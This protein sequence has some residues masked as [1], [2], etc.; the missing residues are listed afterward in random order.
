MAG[1][2]SPHLVPQW[3]RTVPQSRTVHDP[4]K[5]KQ[6]LRPAVVGRAAGGE[7]HTRRAA[8][9]RLGRPTDPAHSGGDDGPSGA[10]TLPLTSPLV[11][12][13]HH[14]VNISPMSYSAPKI[15]Y[16]KSTLA[17][18]SRWDYNPPPF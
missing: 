8:E 9:E 13:L 12:S 16:R 15:D 11:T 1:A 7:Q 6:R 14:H 17:R 5:H 3:H 10:A 4:C 18:G 2:Y